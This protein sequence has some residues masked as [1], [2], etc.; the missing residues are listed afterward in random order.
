MIKDKNH[1][2]A[3]VIA[4]ISVL[5]SASIIEVFAGG[6]WR[7]GRG[8]CGGA[9][10]GGYYNSCNWGFG[11]GHPYYYGSYYGSYP[12]RYVTVETPVVHTTTV[13]TKV[14]RDSSAP[15][16][17]EESAVAKTQAQPAKQLEKAPGDTSTVQQEASVGDTATI[18]V[19]N[20]AGRF[21]SVKLVKH[22]SGYTGPQGEFYPH[23]PTVAQLRVLYS[24]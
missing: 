16:Q 11:W 21:T 5:L 19:P 23:S 3:A 12:Y 10:W 15:T 6:H 22:G 24:Y 1:E 18:Y 17:N 9:R 13:V 20:S 8:G 7:G 4:L 2:K 14:V